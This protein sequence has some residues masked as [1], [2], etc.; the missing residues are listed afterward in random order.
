MATVTEKAVHW[1]DP[2]KPF[3]RAATGF[4]EETVISKRE[5]RLDWEKEMTLVVAGRRKLSDPEVVEV[6]D[7]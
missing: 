7:Q 3:P 6:M 4:E 1:E 2:R 5:Q